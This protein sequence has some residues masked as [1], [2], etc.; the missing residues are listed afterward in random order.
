MFALGRRRTFTRIEKLYLGAVTI[1]SLAILFPNICI[2][3]TYSFK[4]Y[5]VRNGLLSDAVTS[6]CQDSNGYL[7]VG[8]SDG[9]SVY[10]GETFRNY[11][12]TDGLASSLVNCIV[13]DVNHEGVV[14][15]GTNGGGVS[16]FQGGSFSN[17]RMGAS[18]W[19]NRVNGIAQDASGIVYC[20]S[21]D[22]IYRIF[23]GAVSPLGGRLAHGPFVR[24][25]CA[26]DTL[27]TVDGDGRL[28]AFDLVN[29]SITDLGGRIRPYTSVSQICLDEEG[30]TCIVFPN[31][32]LK[33][34]TTGKVVRK[35]AM[36]YPRFVMEDRA[37]TFWIGTSQGVFALDKPFRSGY[38]TKIT[39][40]NGLPEDDIMAGVA[41]R[42]G[43]LWFGTADR[44]LV[45]LEDRRAIEFPISLSRFS[46]N[47]SQGA[48][49]SHGN[50]WV[51]ADKGLVEIYA[52]ATGQLK[53]R[54]I[55]YSGL[56][57][58]S[59]C[60]SIQINDQDEMWLATSNA[61]VY[62]IRIT[63]ESR[64]VPIL[65]V[66]SRFYLGDN[67][68]AKGLLCLYVDST[69]RAWCSVDKLGIIEFNTREAR[70]RSIALTQ[71][72]GLPDN[73]IRAIFRDRDGNMWF[74]GYIGGVTEMSGPAVPGNM[75]LYTSRNGLPDNSIRSIMQDSSGN[76][77]IGTRYGGIAVKN[78]DRFLSIS[79][80]DGLAS[81]GVWAMIQAQ[82]YGA[83]FGTQLG[84]Q[85]LIGGELRGL[86]W[87]RFGEARPVYSCGISRFSSGGKLSRVLWGVD[88]SGV[89]LRD[90][91][92]PA[93]RRVPPPVYITGLLVNGSR[94][95]LE[96]PFSGGGSQIQLAHWENTLTFSFEGISLRDESNLKYLYRLRGV[97][98]DWRTLERRLPV[99]YAALRP[100]R[101]MFE[102]I[103]VGADGRKSEAAANLSF[104]ITPP[105]WE[106]WWFITL[107]G[108]ALAAIV[109]FAVRVR[110]R[111]LIEIERVRARIA[112]DLHDD[113]GAGLTRI[114]ILAEVALRQAE[115]KKQS[116]TGSRGES[117]EAEGESFS[118]QGLVRKIG[119]N[120]RELADSMSD[121]VWSIDPRNVTVH[122]L[123]TRF[124]S[125]A[126]E[127]CEAAGIRLEVDIDDDIETL[128]L[129]PG[130]MRT[131]LLIAKEALNNSVKH[132]SCAR[133]IVGM[134]F[135]SRLLFFNFEDDGR[136][137]VI[138]QEFSGHGLANMR[139][140][141]VKLGG[142]FKLKSAA[143]GGTAIQV[144][145]PLNV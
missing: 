11:T 130:V 145:V 128:R 104:D 24:I 41:D 26:G 58:R 140:R 10:D 143:G 73:S 97:E 69:Q 7:W 21:D 133:I 108:V 100:G 62:G 112:T 81:E 31:G 98:N 57:I 87:K 127:T 23:H 27:F 37:G 6:L 22:G 38:S 67:V 42:E 54:L 68:A 55:P 63:E 99:T 9:A 36:S 96:S 51:A 17:F 59:A 32:D 75:K 101:Y 102:V 74:G 78:A 125:F 61:W 56:G 89:F 120:A 103:A 29:G 25:L 64:Q 5:T 46:V 14:W 34:L 119:V 142:D 15:I 72:D 117:E 92:P 33:N 134:K 8:T 105:F 122:D 138:Y 107:V 91:D 43:D 45:K 93:V 109:Y 132:S 86:S 71:A 84:L 16:R 65:K 110:V 70:Q 123:I 40:A 111:R 129:E 2:S 3:Q 1:A 44:G 118:A 60:V 49:D 137:F 113:I 114:A 13:R 124:R 116:G 135:S 82:G 115:G 19:S 30:H 66:V 35:A 4:T 12:V 141:A 52:I 90:L 88:Q 126:Y 95:R 83:F 39:V 50:I 18:D 76:I 85:E 28:L 136:G 20:A 121:V 79:V 48:P 80:R 47:N 144:T 94:Y 131:L 106:M 139:Q 77:W 53:E